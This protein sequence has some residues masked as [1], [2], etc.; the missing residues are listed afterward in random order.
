MTALEILSACNGILLA[1][2]I[3]AARE[4]W[5]D[6]KKQHQEMSQ[7]INRFTEIY[8]TKSAMFRAHKRIDALE[9]GHSGHEKRLVRIETKLNLPGIPLCRQAT[10]PLP[11]TSLTDCN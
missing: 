9:T 4:F 6:H 11:D 10:S 5:T 1:I 3:F 2:L 8:A 7:L